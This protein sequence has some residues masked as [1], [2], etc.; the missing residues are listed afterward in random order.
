MKYLN[1]IVIISSVIF[2]SDIIEF[3]IIDISGK[4]IDNV[5]VEFIDENNAITGMGQ[6]D[7]SG[8]FYTNYIDDNIISIKFS[9]IGYK[10]KI[11]DITLL[12]DNQNIILEFSNIKSDQIVITGL[13]KQSY[14]K[15]TPVLTRVITSDD[16]KKSAY[17]SVKEA[18]EMSLPNVQNVMSSH[19]GISNEEVK[20]QGLDNKYL[21]FLIDGKRISGEFAGNLDFRMLD[22]SNI[23]R[24]E[25]VEGGMSSL[26]GSSA[27][28]GVINIITRKNTNPFQI[29]YSYLNDNPMINVQSLNM[30][31]EYK[32]FF[33]EINIVN[34]KTDGYDLTPDLNATYPLK[35]LEEY[36][37]FSLGHVLGYDNNKNFNIRM[38]YK[39]YKNDIYLYQNQTLQILDEDD[40][41]YPFYNYV[42]YRDWMP[43]FE[44]INYGININYYKNNSLIN[45]VFNSEEYI[46]SNYFYNY[47]EEPCNQIDCSNSNNVSSEEFINGINKN[48]S[49]LIQYNLD[50]KNNLFTIGFE[51]NDD[52]YSSY[53]IYHYGYTD[54][55]GNFDAGDYGDDGLCGSGTPWDPDDCL[56][57]SIFNSQDDTKYYKKRSYFIGNQWSLLNNKIGASFRYVD[58]EN[59]DDNYVYSISYMI[60]NKPKTIDY[61]PYEI[62]L[63]YSR[64]FRTPSIKELY[65]NWY[66]HSPAI[67]GNQDLVPTTNDYISVSIQRFEQNQDF[68]IE[69]FYNNVI[70]MIGGTYIDVNDDGIDEYQYTNYN[71]IVFL[72]MNIHFNIKNKV[73]AFKF[74][75]NLTNGA[76]DNQSAL[77]LVSRHSFRFN[78]LRN[79][80][81]KKIDISFNLKYSGEKFIL[82]GGERLILD[83]Y[84]LSDL[85]AIINL[86]KYFEFKFGYKNLFDYKDDRR[87]LESGSDFLS[88]YDPGRRFVLELKFNFD[89]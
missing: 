30:G 15:D 66:G 46:K 63:N 83:D 61:Q 85:M 89:R 14:I 4:P 60:N 53:N 67:V 39:N 44:D 40:P 33:Y 49:L 58:S 27:I 82:L 75:Y 81:E 11:I 50:H 54:S 41:N 36:N 45:V 43:K 69:V 64:G 23:D 80:I 19:A 3:K 78:W 59:F 34:Q 6:T 68:S 25:I 47:T 22:L 20:I 10:E 1:I 73:D 16:I 8:F 18:L 28:G 32:N 2:S 26:Y 29:S 12:N 21:L 52:S 31:L 55:D 65:Y 87:L 62:R 74:V 76:S 9:H 77:Q 51:N 71:D 5:F 13:R 86:N 38:N 70:D 42:S 88:T 72:G 56:V 48:N 37:T 84:I 17:S 24:I 7:A 57:E 79:I 35:T